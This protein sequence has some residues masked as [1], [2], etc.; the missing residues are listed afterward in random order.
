M[1]TKAVSFSASW[2]LRLWLVLNIVCV[3]M[4]LWWELV[5]LP[6][7]SKWLLVIMLNDFYS[8]FFYNLSIPCRVVPAD[9]GMRASD[10]I[11]IVFLYLMVSLSGFL[12]WVAYLLFHALTA[13]SVRGVCREQ[14]YGLAFTGGYGVQPGQ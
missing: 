4:V 5:L 8:P 2:S 12:V 13:L 9:A 14:K 1:R 7:C 11:L 3:D 6:T 10:I